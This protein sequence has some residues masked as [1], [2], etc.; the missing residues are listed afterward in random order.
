MQ[1]AQQEQQRV[2]IAIAHAL[3]EKNRR[4]KE[5]RLERYRPYP[6]QAYF[7]DLGTRKRERL[8]MA[9]NQLG[10]TLCAGAEIAMHLTGRYPDWWTGKRFSRPAVIW[11]AGV[12]AE[13]TRDG[14]Q[15]MLFGR[16]GQWGT[17]MIPKS[18]IQ[19]I[20]T[21]RGVA[22]AID[23]AIV[24]WDGTQGGVP[25][26]KQSVVAFKSYDQG[27]E[28]F[29]A[30]TIDVVWFDEEPPLEIY[31]EGL[32]RTNATKG[33][34]MITFTPLMGMSNTVSR[35]MLTPPS[36]S[37]I[38]MMTIDDVEHYTPEEKQRIIDSYPEEERD[39]R[40]KGVPVFG[41]GRVFPVPEEVIRCEP[42]PI[43]VHYFQ[44]A[45]LDFGYDHPTAGARLVWDKDSDVM[46]ITQTVRMRK[47][48][49]PL[50]CAQVR[51]WGQIPWAWPHDG[52]QHDK[53]SGLQLA[54]QY[55]D[56]GLAMLSEHATHEAGGN[57]LEAG[58]LE[59][60]ERFQTGR[61][62]VFANCEEFFEEFRIYHRKDGK[63]VKERDDVLSAVRYAVMMRRYAKQLRARREYSS[64]TTASVGDTEIGY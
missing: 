33:F 25:M 16:P 13:G 27:R 34:A 20:K 4:K 61:L 3:E 45:G 54:A 14:A 46:Y 22:D 35:F 58:L 36:D 60:L 6:K 41:S 21:K 18:C 47:A 1:V 40:T 53:G 23:Y 24:R 38:V 56:N 9:G 39:A 8:L 49:P 63:V 30:E 2:R 62:K 64:V 7:H 57:G 37:E 19:E 55:K 10:K 50:F 31:M 17:G 26:G 52:Y 42:F 28:K 44:I 5:N 59:M 12:T 43:P 48:L 15:R 29:Q 32:T 51:G 11:V